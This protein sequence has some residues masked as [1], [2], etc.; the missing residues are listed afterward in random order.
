MR[1]L[2]SGVGEAFDHLRPNTSLL[3]RADTGL[4]PCEL[5][6][7][8][9]FTA[10]DAY[11]RAVSSPEYRLPGSP[12]A[13]HDGPDLVW[14]SHFHGDHF[15]GL[16]AL[17]TRLKQDGRTRDLWVAG[18]EGLGSKV[19]QVLDMAYPG[20]REKLGYAV[21]CVECLPGEDKQ[22]LGLTLR[23]ALTTHAEP[24]LALRL[25]A[26]DQT[27]YYSGDGAPTS[28][29][30][31]LAWD[32]GLIVQ[33]AYALEPDTPGHGSVVEAVEL[34][35]VTGAKALA[36]VHLNRT[37]REKGLDSVKTL[38]DPNCFVPEPGHECQ[39]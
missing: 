14:I 4:G 8:C 5:L 16:P 33:E 17:A 35:R 9:G 2:F 37:L 25:S 21:R 11:W 15:F 39:V 24:C 19:R 18:G 13:S 10:P 22:C 34:A 1:V 7:D 32:C 6:L 29:C 20:L 26:G 30:L 38:L 36:L 3:V 28:D 12:A 27:L 31:A 23:T